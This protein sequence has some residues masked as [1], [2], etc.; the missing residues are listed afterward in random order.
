MTMFGAIMMA[1]YQREKTGEGKYV[2]TSLIAN[3]CWANGMHLQ[4]AIAGY[5][6]GSILDEKGYRSPFSMIYK[7]RDDRYIVLV[8]T[9][10]AKEWSEI[11][12]GLGHPEWIDDERFP[13]IRAIMKRR[14]EVRDLFAEAIGSKNLADV[15]LALDKE[16]LTYGLIERI[17]EV[18]EDAHLIEN[19]VIIKTNSDNPDYQWTVANPI[20][21]RGEDQRP[22][23]DAPE[24]GE[25]SR[26]ILAESGH[27]E[28]EI[29]KLLASGVVLAAKS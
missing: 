25:H 1:L 6:L 7:T 14:D 5:D 24:I 21:I 17:S 28:E 20:L 18:V 27:S 3:G 15:C 12:R 9:N 11:A 29:E 8:L 22:P 26:E 10:P 23:S 16:H 4:G 2:E 19:K 13:D